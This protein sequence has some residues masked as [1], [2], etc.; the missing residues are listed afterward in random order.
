MP[1]FLSD[2]STAFYI[3]L[4]IVV[5]VAAI[6]WFRR[7]DRATTIRFIIALILCLGVYLCDRFVES[8]REEAVRRIESMV[9][10]VNQ[11]NATEFLAQVSESFEY[12]GRKKAEAD[13]LIDLAR[14]HSVQVS[15]WDF[16]RD[17]VTFPSENQVEIVF[18][19]KAESPSGG[20]FLRH[21]RARFVKDPDGQWRMQTFTP[22]NI[23]QKE[24]GG[25]EPIPGF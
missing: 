24:I 23:A 3:V 16:A 7:Q 15:V 9:T 19:A 21:V 1:T 8:P 25:E 13:R 2:P 11:R 22:Y 4:L 20:P 5:A 10:A 17:R 14:Q 6:M 18:D 12:K